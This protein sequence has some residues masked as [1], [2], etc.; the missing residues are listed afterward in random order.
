MSFTIVA[1][2]YVNPG[3]E[4]EFE[5][6][7]SAAAAIMNRYGGRIERRIGCDPG[8]GGDIPHEV[9]IVTFPDQDSFARYRGDAELN[10]LA[11][12][13][14]RAIRSTVVWRGADLPPFGGSPG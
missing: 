4:A 3:R 9:H 7:E 10:A 2:L 13:R 8:P 14:A 1:A 5:Q 12:L 11:G 6:F